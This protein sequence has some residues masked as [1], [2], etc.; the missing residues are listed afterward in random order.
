VIGQGR[1]EILEAVGV[2]G[3][4]WMQYLF[5]P[6]FEV[7]FERRGVQPPKF[8]KTSDFLPKLLKFRGKLKEKS[9][10]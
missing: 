4:A 7:N 6:S 2:V 9:S 1:T 8:E 10:F 5:F 3:R